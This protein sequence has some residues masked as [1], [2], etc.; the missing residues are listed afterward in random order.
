VKLIVEDDGRGFEVTDAMG[1]HSYADR[2]GLYGMRER[3]S[4]L[5][6]SLTIES[7]AGRG[8][9]IFVEIPLDRQERRREQ[10]QAVGG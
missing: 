5:D 9:T 8:T 4:L 1:S 3:A 7:T 10:D 2:L 6:G